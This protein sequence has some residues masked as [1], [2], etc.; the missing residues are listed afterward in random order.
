MEPVF[1]SIR[2]TA[3]TAGKSPSRAEFLAIATAD[4]GSKRSLGLISPQISQ[5]NADFKSI[6]E[7][8]RNQRDFKRTGLAAKSSFTNVLVYKTQA[9]N[10]D[11]C[12]VISEG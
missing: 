6:G 1:C 10:E 3:K 7:N 5:I 2:Y 11:R 8:Q 9:R 12:A 4:R